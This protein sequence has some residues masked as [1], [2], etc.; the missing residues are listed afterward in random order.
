MIRQEGKEGRRSGWKTGET[1]R[2]EEGGGEK[3]E[4]ED[5]REWEGEG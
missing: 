5:E 2:G 4:S 3:R 1:G